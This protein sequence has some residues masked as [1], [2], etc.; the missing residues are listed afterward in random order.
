MKR[1]ILLELLYKQSSLNREKILNMFMNVVD[2][3]DV[4]KRLENLL[5]SNI[6]IGPE[7]TE[8]H[9]RSSSLLNEVRANPKEAINLF[10]KLEDMVLLLE[11]QK[12]ISEAALEN[13]DFFDNKPTVVSKVLSE[14]YTA[15]YKAF[16]KALTYLT[17]ILYGVDGVMLWSGFPIGSFTDLINYID[18]V[19]AEKIKDIKP[20]VGKWYVEDRY[21][22][23]GRAGVSYNGYELVYEDDCIVENNGTHSHPFMRIGG[24]DSQKTVEGYGY[25]TGVD[26]ENVVSLFDGEIINEVN[27]SAQKIDSLTVD[28]SVLY[29]PV[30]FITQVLGTDKFILRPEVYVKLL[31]KY[32]FVRTVAERNNNSKCIMC[33]R[34]IGTPS[35]SICSNHFDYNQN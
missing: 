7:A 31:N 25:I 24:R 33:G 3:T 26:M 13:S 6:F 29:N 4:Y 1:I 12:Q 27:V 21:Y 34:V 2:G 22:S 8:A 17:V 30:A 5:N 28:E 32:F 23:G 18:T 14:E 9:Q 35:V 11:K 20:T 19:L 15:F 16:Y 10:F